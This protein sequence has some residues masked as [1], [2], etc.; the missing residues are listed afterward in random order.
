MRPE[1][2]TGGAGGTAQRSLRVLLVNPPNQGKIEVAIHRRLLGKDFVYP[3]LGLLYLGSYIRSRRPAHEVRLLDCQ[4]ERDGLAALHLLLRSWSPDA[5]GVSVHTNLLLPALDVCRLVRELAPAAR[6]VTGGPHVSLFPREM[7]GF[8]EVDHA[9]REEGESP[10][11]ALLDR[12]ASGSRDMDGIPGVLHRRGDEV[13]DNGA[14][15]LLDDLDSL[16]HPERSLLPV[17]RYRM[18]TSRRSH[19]TTVLTSR[20]CPYRC[21]FCDVSQHHVRFHSPGWVVDELESCLRSGVREVH[22][23]D[24]IFNLRPGRVA[25]ISE[26]IRQRGLQ[27]DWSFRGRVDRMD[28]AMLAGARKAG[29]YRVYLGLESGSPRTLEAMRKGHSV[30]DIRRGVAKARRAGLEVH[31]YFMLGYP[32][33][34]DNDIEATVDLALSLDLDFAQF[35]VT[36][37]LPG[38]RIYESA[39]AEG[40]LEAD[41]WRAQAVE[42]RADFEAPLPAAFGVGEAEVWR[43]ANLAYRRFYHRPRMVW[44]SLRSIRSPQAL[45][46]RIKGAA[47]S[48]TIGSRR[49][50]GAAPEAP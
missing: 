44:R 41:V 10:L 36:T 15:E 28:A 18:L 25:E 32:G 11:T 35:S 43:A 27:L 7:M 38:T 19:C 42:P 23:F 49:E 26:G 6:V 4:A 29:C 50:T 9:V 17:R 45:L 47:L 39:L 3:P 2:H 22:I 20:G 37:Y 33:E 8:P 5:V 48:L 34:T 13:V 1:V 24:D 14:G 12:L 30:D 40:Q 31:G 16:P 21:T 46:R